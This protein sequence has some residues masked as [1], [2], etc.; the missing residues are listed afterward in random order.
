MPVSLFARLHD[1]ANDRFPHNVMLREIRDFDW[2]ISPAGPIENWSETVRHAA[3]TVLLSSAPMAFL[4]GSE[5]LLVYNDAMRAMFGSHYDH[6]LGKPVIEVLPNAA[7]F[8]RAAIDAALAGRASSFCEEPF[9]IQRKGVRGSAWFNLE[10]TP[11]AD[12]GGTIHGTLLIA[13]EATERVLAS[14]DLRHS[15]ERLD[16]AL[17]AGGII[18]T[19]EV[20][21]TTETVSSDERFARLH[22]IDPV[23]ARAGADREVFTS[24]IHADDRAHAMA[25][26]DRA[27]ECGNYH[28]Q[29]RVVG[30]SGTR[31][32]VSSGRMLP[33]QEGRP[34][35]FS[36]VVVDVTQQVETAAALAESELRFRT[37]T[38]TLPQIVFSWDAD[39]RNDYYNR[40][41]PEFT[42][43]PDRPVEPYGW[44][45][46]LHSDD[47]E[48][49]LA[50]W[51]H[52]MDT[53][54]RHD[55]EARYLHHS[56]EYRWARIIALPIHGPD[57]QVTGW[58]GTL[59][60][61]QTAKLLETERELVA[62][63]L[64]HRIKNLFSVV[65]GLISLTLR[66]DHDAQSFANRLRGRLTALDQA[67]DFVKSGAGGAVARQ[68][69][70]SLQELVRRL[71]APYDDD[72]QQARLV[73]EGDDARVDEGAAT[74]LALIFHELAT[75][76]TKYGA[77]SAIGG[78]IHLRSRRIDQL[79]QLV[80]EESGGEGSV[81]SPTS[82][83]F[84]S[85]LLSLVI[86]GQLRGKLSRET[87]PEGIR[88]QMDLPLDSLAKPIA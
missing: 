17:N 85:R 18:G 12:E 83:G 67:H 78:K 26:F 72:G 1:D 60:D 77:L 5:G 52:A 43:Q 55:T 74:P 54:E 6:S 33:D 53:G 71:L 69:G 4:I 62:R 47:R 31:W 24:G 88:I 44:Q 80:W 15:R 14:H 87:R 75:N 37:Y 46:M 9:T 22:G 27:K 32:V 36:G 66:E 34:G 30:D 49:M 57:D 16:L 68:T 64:D 38:E 73:I 7:D 29:H 50:S 13:N 23:V 61:I 58:V 19:W 70:N 42:G 79:L 63:E 76:A 25:E 45:A 39:G 11:I 81:S 59:T 84:G 10:F 41:W 40:R 2:A 86:E 48:R 65:N 20:D 82:G 35:S 28:C 56:G 21:F 3:R 51:R 8:C